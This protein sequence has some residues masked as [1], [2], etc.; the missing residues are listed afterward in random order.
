VPDPRARALALAQND[1][2]GHETDPRAPTLSILEGALQELPLYLSAFPT[3]STATQN[4]DD[5]HETDDR[6]LLASIVV[7]AL[8]ELPL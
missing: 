5:G 6:L 3:L 7:G 2:D 1:D 8:H 4:D